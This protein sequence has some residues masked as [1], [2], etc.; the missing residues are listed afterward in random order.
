MRLLRASGLLIAC[1]SLFACASPIKTMSAREAIQ[2]GNDQ[3]FTMPSYRMDISSKVISMNLTEE[4]EDEFKRT[5]SFNKYMNFFSKNFV[6]NGTGVFDT[7]KDQYQIIP[8]YGYEAKN[9]NAR[10]RFP[11]VLDRK[12][13]LLYVD[14]SA[15]D[16]LMT[17]INNAGK[18][19][20]F[21]LSKLPIAEDTDKKLVDLMRKY[22]TLMFDKIPE[23]AISEQPLNAEDRKLRT[24]RKL[25]FALKPQDQLALYPEMIDDIMTVVVPSASATQDE[26]KQDGEKMKNELAEL[27]APESRDLYTY[28]F[29]RAGQIVAVSADSNY[30]IRSKKPADESEQAQPTGSATTPVT[31]SGFQMHFVTNMTVRDIGKA[32]LIDPPTT[33]NSVDGIENLKGSVFGKSLADKFNDHPQESDVSLDSTPAETATPVKKPSKKSHQKKR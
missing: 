33:E 31:P 18:Y 32:Q 23:Q 7:V 14:L 19:S 28:S 27:F 24:V 25:Q 12:A 2:F 5:D 16:G 20:R 22:T 6:F 10:I 17:D 21:D 8:E 15:L 1:A 26:L 13:K 4:H 30:M 29:N 9:I 11:L 3:F